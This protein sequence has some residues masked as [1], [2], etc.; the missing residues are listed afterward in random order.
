MKNLFR[1]LLLLGSL[2]APVFAA[3]ADDFAAVRRS[4]QERISATIAGDAE[5]LGGLLSEQ[6][7][8][9][10]SDGRVQGKRQF[11]AAVTS[12][13]TKYISVEPR[14][15][16]YESIADG[17]V[18]TTGR[19]HLVVMANSTRLEFEL[20]FLAVWRQESG[21]WRLLAYQSAQLPSEA[22]KR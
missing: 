1:S 17:S 4:D 8:Y 15:V 6:L 16:E 9:A 2:F 11:I 7:R 14:D 5:K 12:S 10:H 3:P 22:T 21:Q 20:H 19:A 13:K 18:L